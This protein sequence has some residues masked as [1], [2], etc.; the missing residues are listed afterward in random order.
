MCTYPVRDKLN[1]KQ[2]LTHKRWYNK[3]NQLSG[4]VEGIVKSG[5]DSA[6]DK[7]FY[8]GWFNYM[9]ELSSSRRPLTGTL[10]IGKDKRP[11]VISG[12]HNIS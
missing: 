10:L 9:S 2:L 1:H 8:A 4:Y 7:A 6:R 12:L 5:I 3:Y 11:I